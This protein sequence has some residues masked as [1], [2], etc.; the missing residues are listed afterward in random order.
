MDF[1]IVCWLIWKC[2][3]DWLLF[4]WQHAC[5]IPWQYF[6]FLGGLLLCDG[7]WRFGWS[8]FTLFLNQEFGEMPVNYQFADS[9]VFLRSWHTHPKGYMFFRLSWWMLVHGICLDFFSQCSLF[10]CIQISC[11]YCDMQDHLHIQKISRRHNHNSHVRIKIISGHRHTLVRLILYLRWMQN[12]CICTTSGNEVWHLQKNPQ[13][14]SGMI[15]FCCIL[16]N[17]IYIMREN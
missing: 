14:W 11:D 16:W 4:V 12:T 6:V 1:A 13:P 10:F 8:S 15:I 3:I 2:W 5:C 7:Q 17:E 9:I